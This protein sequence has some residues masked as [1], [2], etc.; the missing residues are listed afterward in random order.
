MRFFLIATAIHLIATNGLYRT[1][2]KCSHCVTAT[3]SPAPVQPIV[4]KNKSQLQIAQCERTLKVKKTSRSDRL[5]NHQHFKNFS[6]PACYPRNCLKIPETISKLFA[7]S[8]D[9][10]QK[11]RSL[12]RS[13]C[14]YQDNDSSSGKKKHHPSRNIPLNNS[15]ALEIPDNLHHCICSINFSL[16]QWIHIIFMNILQ[17]G[18]AELF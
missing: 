15:L 13:G 17:T 2:W 7:I 8:A 3:T 6:L 18:M 16:T 9:I 14:D 5:K 1:Q 12:G 11:L 10:L 4:R